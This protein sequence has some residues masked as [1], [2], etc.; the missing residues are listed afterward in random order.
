MRERTADGGS[1]G[2]KVKM[3]DLELHDDLSDEMTDA[4]GMAMPNY[5]SDEWRELGERLNE[6]YLKRGDK[7]NKPLAKEIDEVRSLMR[8]GPR[9]HP[10]EFIADGR[11]RLL[12]RLGHDA[13]DYGP[14][15]D[16]TPGAVYLRT[17]G[18]HS[19]VLPIL[20]DLMV[21]GAAAAKLGR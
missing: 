15:Q 6:L 7:P 8:K 17:S 12:D 4:V 3:D 18:P 1:D 9:L 13:W 2:S 10:G 20:E 21:Q 14:I 11:Y 19:P 5:P 16:H